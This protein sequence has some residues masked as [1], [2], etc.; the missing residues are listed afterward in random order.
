MPPSPFPDV[1]YCIVFSVMTANV[2]VIGAG[3]VGL[4]TAINIQRLVPSCSV[5][6]VAED[7]VEGTASVGAGAIFRPTEEYL[8]GVDIQRARY[9]STPKLKPSLGYD[10]SKSFMYIFSPQ[11]MT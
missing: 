11:K 1:Q 8:P 2:V 10:L 3:A 5:T 7:V 4:S 9:T 6:I